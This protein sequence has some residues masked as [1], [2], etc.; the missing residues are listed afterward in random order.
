MFQT[1][2]RYDANQIFHGLHISSSDEGDYD[3][4]DEEEESDTDE[5][6]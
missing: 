6:T 3:D 1:N 4:S 5:K 2:I